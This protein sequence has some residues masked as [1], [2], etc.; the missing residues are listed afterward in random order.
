[1]LKDLGHEGTDPKED[2]NGLTHLM[3][4]NNRFTINF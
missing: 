2:G 3:V 4:R 1:M